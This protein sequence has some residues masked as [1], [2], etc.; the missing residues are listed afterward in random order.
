M[1]RGG[2][3]SQSPIPYQII[4]GEIM[5]YPQIRVWLE[6]ANP[7]CEG[8]SDFELISK[9]AITENHLTSY[10]MTYRCRVCGTE[11]TI[12]VDVK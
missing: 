7:K 11:K 6:C 9:R 1:E 4:G 10:V 3:S 5:S 12:G 8:S 2:T